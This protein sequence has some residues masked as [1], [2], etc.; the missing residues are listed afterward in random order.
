[1]AVDSKIV[2][3]EAA[4][5]AMSLELDNLVDACL[6]GIT[7]KDIARARAALPP[8]CRHAYQKEVKKGV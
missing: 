2:I 8:Y 6:T 3:L 5:K 4:L 1:M 7:P